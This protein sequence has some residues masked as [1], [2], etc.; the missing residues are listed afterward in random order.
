[1][2]KITKLFSLLLAATFLFG[3]FQLTTSAQTLAVD[4]DKVFLWNDKPENS[5][6]ELLGISDDLT[7]TA[8]EAAGEW[9]YIKSP[10]GDYVFITKWAAP[11]N[12]VIEIPATLDGYEVVGWDVDVNDYLVNELSKIDYELSLPDNFPQ[13]MITAV[14][15]LDDLTEAEKYDAIYLGFIDMISLVAP[16]SFNISNKNKFLTDVDGVLYSKDKTVLI[17]YPIGRETD[18]FYLPKKAKTYFISETLDDCF[19]TDPFAPVFGLY[20]EILRKAENLTVHVHDEQMQAYFDWYTSRNPEDYAGFALNSLTEFYA[21]AKTI[22]TEWNSEMLKYFTSAKEFLTFWVGEEY[23]A[24]FP[25]VVSCNGPDLS[26]FVWWE[27]ILYV[28]FFG[29]I[30]Y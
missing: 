16:T 14:M 26:Y 12:G 2:K 27:W 19:A 21:G 17:R 29:W 4:A 6:R 8:A 9:E 28:F 10:Y 7:V 18:S 23:V 24:L 25:D 15:G 30:W 1:M 20:G 13:A 5:L 3:S 11:K 22:C